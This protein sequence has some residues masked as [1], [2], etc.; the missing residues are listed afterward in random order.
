MY[1]DNIYDNFYGLAYGIIYCLFISKS[2][3]S[4]RIVNI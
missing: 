4:L 1:N 3:L 2:L